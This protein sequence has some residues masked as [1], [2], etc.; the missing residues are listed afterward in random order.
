MKKYANL[1]FVYA[2]AA[3]VFGV[4]YREFTKLS[5]YGGET[6]LSVMH[7]H[8]FVLGMLFFLVVL[9]LEHAFKLGGGKLNKAFLIV[10][11]IGLVIT[12][13]AFFAR[14]FLQVTLGLQ[15]AAMASG[16][17]ASISGIAGIGHI[18]LGTGIILLFIGLQKALKKRVAQAVS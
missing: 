7:T 8:F 11:N 10:Y 13:G 3:M 16:L 15:G 5:G 14:G 1:A 4:F 17:D 2:I 12:G 18:L 9:L 6:T